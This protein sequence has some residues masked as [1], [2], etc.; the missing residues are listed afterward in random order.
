MGPDMG[1]VFFWKF[2]LVELLH[3]PS[4]SLYTVC[5]S[6]DTRRM[7]PQYLQVAHRPAVLA[8]VATLSETS[9]PCSFAM[10][11]IAV[12]MPAAAAPN[13]ARLDVI[14]FP[15]ILANEVKLAPRDAQVSA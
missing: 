6:A 1:V 13:T 4:D 10:A 15:L 14:R 5:L 7:P 11:V 2:G 3:H 8:G 12:A 9:L